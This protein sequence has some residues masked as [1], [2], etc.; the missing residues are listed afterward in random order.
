[1]LVQ[2]ELQTQHFGDKWWYLKNA[3]LIKQ[4]LPNKQ[5]NPSI[6][7]PQKRNSMLTKHPQKTKQKHLLQKAGDEFFSK[8]Q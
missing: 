8:A 1:M 7:H 6:P 5:T 4:T 3:S 2:F